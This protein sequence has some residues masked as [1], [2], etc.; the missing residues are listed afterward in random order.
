MAPQARAAGQAPFGRPAKIVLFAG[1]GFA[2]SYG[3]LSEGS[4]ISTGDAVVSAYVVEIRAPIDGTLSGMPLASGAV[5]EQGAPLAR[6]H[7]PLADRQHLDNLNAQAEAAA[8]AV[9]SLSREQ[10]ALSAQRA[11]LLSHA[12]AHDRAVAGRLAS[13]VAEAERTAASHAAELAQA[14]L[15]LERGEKLH[16]AGILSVAE[17]ER[18]RSRRE[19]AAAQGAAG[20]AAE[21]ALRAQAAAA[22]RGIMAEPGQNMD[23]SYSQQRAD[24][25]AIKIAENARSLGAS[26]AEARFLRTSAETEAVRADALV[27]AELRSPITGM[28]W[29]LNATDGERTAAGDTL[30]GLVD[31]SRQ[32]VLARIPQE[33]VPDVAVHSRARYRL[34]G[35]AVD[36]TGLVLSVAGEG[37]K[38]SVKR[39][40]AEPDPALA[41]TEAGATVLI[42]PD[43]TAAPASSCEI[44]R[45]ARVL[46]PTVPSTL[47]SRWMRRHL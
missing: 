9:E 19:I 24:E 42:A 20:R 12:A 29:D 28:L 13:Q 25:I 11:H 5:V 45:T 40:A 8:A 21:N 6:I 44:G 33:R 43:T 14:Q 22:S 26:E 17:I 36:R 1:L 27:Q 31:C 30:L 2:G 4:Y 34:A 18:L 38:I 32:F 3:L 47:A 10:D 15:D 16:A 35:E 39:L 23:V 37:K 46:I 7:N 41:R